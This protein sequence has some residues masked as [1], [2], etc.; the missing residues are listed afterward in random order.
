MLNI[1]HRSKKILHYSSFEIQ[2]SI[3]FKKRFIKM[4]VPSDS[5][6]QLYR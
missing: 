4:P 6:A 2:C 5:S 1:E 3:L